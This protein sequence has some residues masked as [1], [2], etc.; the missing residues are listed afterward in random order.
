MSAHLLVKRV[1]I[2][3]LKHCDDSI[4]ELSADVENLHLSY[5]SND[6]KCQIIVI[7]GKPGM[8]LDGFVE[9]KS[10]KWRYDTGAINT[11]ITDVYMSILLEHRPVLERVKKQFTTADGR[12]IKIIGTAK[13]LL[14]FQA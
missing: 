4:E 10:L 14:F 13:M 7:R 6:G 2:G 9:G 3:E 8:R 5:D 1:S 12:K 11:F